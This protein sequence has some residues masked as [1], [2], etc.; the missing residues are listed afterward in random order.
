MKLSTIAFSFVFVLSGALHTLGNTTPQHILEKKITLRFENAAFG[1]VVRVLMN[2]YDV[3]IGFEESSLDTDHNDY[4]FE[5][6]L[7]RGFLSREVYKVQKNAISI[8]VVDKPLD[9][10]LDSIV[11]Q[12]R[13]YSWTLDDGVVNIFPVEGRDE[14][15]RSFLELRIASFWMPKNSPIHRIRLEIEDSPEV[16]AFVAKAGVSIPV[17]RKGGGTRNHIIDQ[18][19]DLPGLTL[20]ELLNQVTKVKRGGWALKRNKFVRNPTGNKIDLD[21]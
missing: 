11:S 1:E 12:M 20:K 9:E 4:D 7:A 10:V 21:L 18:E 5:T 14:V 2:R 8:D 15:F 13:F 16:K 6:N 3:A 19:L 17:L